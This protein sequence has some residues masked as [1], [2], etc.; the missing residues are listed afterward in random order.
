MTG[1]GRTLRL[2]QRLSQRDLAILLSLRQLRLLTGQQLQRL[3]F[4][5]GHRP[6]QA[7][8]T[9]AA[10]KRLSELGVI[11]RLARRMGGLHAGSDGYVI[12][13]SGLGFAVLDASH[14]GSGRRHRRVNDTKPAF[15]DH[16]LAV[17]DLYVQLTEDDRAGH[18]EL[19]EFAAEP[20]A[21]RHFSGSGGQRV[22]LKPDAYVRL[23]VG[24]YE[25]AAFIEQDMDTESTPTIA[26]KLGVYINYWRSGLEQ[27]ARDVFP[28]VWWLVPDTNRL[29]ELSRTIRRVPEDARQ[30]FKVAL[31]SHAATQLTQLPDKG[32][33]L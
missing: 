31:T 2:R 27:R 29:S 21:W 9:R 6:T 10:L 32:G 24:D 11:V 20:E 3:H 4:A 30:L 33:A 17:S 12:G 26:R 14:S 23:G 5:D 7:R 15:Q 19:L 16:V 18:S 1:R 28:L 13:L 25:L 8:K 22:T